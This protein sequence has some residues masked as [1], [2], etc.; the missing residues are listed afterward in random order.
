VRSIGSDFIHTPITSNHTTQLEHFVLIIYVWHS[1][2]LAMRFSFIPTLL[3]HTH[4]L[5]HD[6]LL[7]SLNH[8]SRIDTNH[9]LRQIRSKVL[10]PNKYVLL[11][12][13]FGLLVRRALRAPVFVVVPRGTSSFLHRVG[14]PPDIQPIILSTFT[15]TLH[16]C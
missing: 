11:P 10:A 2:P 8:Q 15:H 13:V 4:K 1:L 5:D 12:S 16:H 3:F 6:E 7:H 14:G 9:W